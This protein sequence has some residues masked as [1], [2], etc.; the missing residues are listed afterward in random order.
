MTEKELRKLKRAE[1]LEMLIQLKKEND[2]LS[3][4]LDRAKEELK[5]RKIKIANAGSIAEAALQ[6]NEVFEAADR[7]A[8]Q[9]LESLGGAMQNVRV[10]QT[11]NSE[12][13][14]AETREKCR[15]MLAE[16]EAKCQAMEKQTEERCRALMK[17]MKAF[18]DAN[19]GLAEAMKRSVK[20]NNNGKK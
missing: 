12:N 9:Y 18:C 8:A 5:E 2:S 4:Q 11:Q 1:L 10:P 17:K 7:A 14:E 13:L 16:T 20:G 15:K 3:V 19:P 6:L